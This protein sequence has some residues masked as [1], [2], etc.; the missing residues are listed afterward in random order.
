MGVAFLDVFGVDWLEF[1]ADF[2][3]VCFFVV[4]GIAPPS[5]FL[6]VFLSFSI[7]AIAASSFGN[8]IVALGRSV[9]FI[10][11]S[12][13]ETS[14]SEWFVVSPLDSCCTGFS[15]CVGFFSFSSPECLHARTI[16]VLLHRAESA[17]VRGCLSWGHV[18]VLAI[19]RF[20]VRSVLC[21]WG[22][23]LAPFDRRAHKR[24]VC[25]MAI[26]SAAVKCRSSTVCS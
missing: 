8:S 23:V 3:A 1:A 10:R 7:F 2:A 24:R 26:P 20:F 19:S 22:V 13:L 21:P 6:P 18:S 12:S 25:P 4:L 16:I 17:G 9:S 15:C 14:S 5:V 11:V